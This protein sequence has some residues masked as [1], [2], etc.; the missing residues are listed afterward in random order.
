MILMIS[1]FWLSS[2]LQFYLI[3]VLRYLGFGCSMDICYSTKFHPW[4]VHIL[5][6]WIIDV[7]DILNEYLHLGDVYCLI[8]KSSNNKIGIQCW[9]YSLGLYIG[10][11]LYSETAGHISTQS[12]VTYFQNCWFP[13]MPYGMLS[14]PIPIR[15]YF[16]FVHSPQ[17]LPLL[18][19]S[20]ILQ[21]LSM[22]S[23]DHRFTSSWM[24]REDP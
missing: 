21:F 14:H 6:W 19:Q 5:A 22:L 8:Y 4:Y 13:V 3:Y 15:Y 11:I 12:N 18:H 24:W 1:I 7:V 16:A 23:P 20:H 17:C 10:V 9:T 2:S